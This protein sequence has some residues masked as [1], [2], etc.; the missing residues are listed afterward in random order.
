MHRTP[1]RLLVILSNSCVSFARQWLDF[2]FIQSFAA[3]QFASRVRYDHNDLYFRAFCEEV[4]CVPCCSRKLFATLFDG[5]SDTQKIRQNK[6][7]EKLRELFE[8]SELVISFETTE[9]S[10]EKKKRKKIIETKNGILNGFKD[11]ISTVVQ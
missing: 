3:I 2:A 11:N 8:F 1:H 5:Q 10:V 9:Y 4:L 6:E 7:R